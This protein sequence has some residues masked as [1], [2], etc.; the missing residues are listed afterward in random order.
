M[1]PK[2]SPRPSPTRA[3]RLRQASALRREHQREQLRQ[4]ILTAAGELF[5]AHGYEGFSLRQVAERIGYSATTIYRYFTN[6]DDLLFALVY[7]GFQ[8]F[9]QAL[10]A[11]AHSTDDPLR[12]LEALG[13]AYIRFGLQHPVHY[14]LMFM[15]RADLLFRQRAG[16]TSPPIE[17]FDLLQRAVQQALA[18][19]ILRQGDAETYSHALWALVHGITSLAVAQMPSFTMPDLEDITDVALHMSIEG[20]RRR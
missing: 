13:R 8:E 1:P 15:Q 17:S 7:E 9:E 11:A 14:Q 20:L 10:R 16:Q 18:A 3:E 19:G 4:T 2:K 12:R 5:L 6:K